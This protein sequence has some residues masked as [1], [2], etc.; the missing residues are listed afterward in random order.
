VISEYSGPFSA[1]RGFGRPLS[2]IP[3]SIHPPLPGIHSVSLVLS[4]ILLLYHFAGTL[5][6]K[7]L[8]AVLP[9]ESDFPYTVRVNS[10]VMASDGSTSMASVCG[11][12]HHLPLMLM[13]VYLTNEGFILFQLCLRED[14]LSELCC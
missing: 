1:Y 10:E 4:F 7:A 13:V 12:K 11:G 2:A 6:E 5:A 14:I 9:P 3:P 8:L